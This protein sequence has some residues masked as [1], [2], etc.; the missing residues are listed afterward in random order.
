MPTAAMVLDAMAPMYGLLG[1]D[2]WSFQAVSHN[3][4]RT[5]AAI[6][7]YTRWGVSD[8]Y[9]LAIHFGKA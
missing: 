6:K 8:V 1:W 7:Q 5:V 4:D 3:E 2:P 9:F